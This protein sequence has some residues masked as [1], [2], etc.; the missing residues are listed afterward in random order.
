[1]MFVM[2]AFLGFLGIPQGLIASVRREAAC[3]QSPRDRDTPG[4][5][6]AAAAAVRSQRSCQPQRWHENVERLI[7]FHAPRLGLVSPVDF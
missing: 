1:M 7:A 5:E 6:S 4:A 3:V 2:R